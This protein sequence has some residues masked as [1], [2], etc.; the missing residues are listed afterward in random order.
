MPPWFN[1]GLANYMAAMPYQSGR[2]LFTNPGSAISTSIRDYKKYTVASGV[3]PNGVFQMVHPEQLFATDHQTWNATMG[4]QV[5]SSRNYTSA[6]VLLYYFMHEDGNGD[7][8]HFIQWMHAWRTA[9]FSRKSSQYENLIEK[10]LLRGRDHTEL[11]KD[12]Q[13]AMRRK[14]LRLA[15]AN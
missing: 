3:I 9:V 1:E 6:T 14:G 12:I 8:E 4:N 2:L 15:F 11:E 7:G 10:H 13:D 5:A